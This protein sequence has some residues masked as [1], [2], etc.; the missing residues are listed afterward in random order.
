MTEGQRIFEFR[1]YTAEPGKMAALE[2]RFRDDGTRLFQKHGMDVIGYFVLIDS[3][4]TLVYILGFQDSEDRERCWASF[5]AD[6]EWISIRA[7]TEKEGRLTA[8]I[9]ALVL[10]STDYSPLR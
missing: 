10:T 2:Q 6:Q 3:D 1:T 4:D 5:R 7:E 8:H 9:D